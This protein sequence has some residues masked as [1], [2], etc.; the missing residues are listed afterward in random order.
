[1]DYELEKFDRIKA[2]H[3]YVLKMG[4]E[5]FYLSFSGGKDSTALSAL[6]DMALSGNKIPRVYVNTGISYKLIDEFVKELSEKDERIVII[7]PQ[8]PIKPTLEKYG[9]PFKSKL[10]SHFL[11]IYKRRGKL[12]GVKNYIGEGEKKLFRPC[13]QKLLY[14]FTPEFNLKISDFCCLKMKEEP[15]TNWAKENN[16]DIAI[17]GI[18]RA[19]GGRRAKA[20]CIVKRGKLTFFNPIAK[21]T[22]SF[23][24][25]FIQNE[26]IEICKLYKEPFNFKR[27]GCKGCPF[28]IELEQDLEVLEKYFPNERKQCEIIWKPIY[29]EYRKIGYRLK[30]NKNED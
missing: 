5:R 15:L 6:I 12:Y 19:E 22:G 13:P 4:E 29:D 17:T 8:V 1:M 16:K 23:I 25:D 18:T 30:E 3:D 21:V 9:Y 14:Q 26:G 28:N 7:N 27:T 24:N 10:H 11:E 2:I 20:N